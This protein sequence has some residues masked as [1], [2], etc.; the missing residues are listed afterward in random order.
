MTVSVTGERPNWSDKRKSNY[1][2]TGYYISENQ[3]K[4]KN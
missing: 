1:G 4:I 3:I 2:S